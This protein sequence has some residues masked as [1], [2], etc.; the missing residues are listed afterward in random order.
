MDV[1]MPE[2]DGLEATA[3]IRQRENGGSRVP[4]IAMTAHALKGDRQRGLETGMGDYV[5][6][7][8]R[9]EELFPAI[10]TGDHVNLRF[11]AHTLRGA[12]RYFGACR[13]CAH[14]PWNWKTWDARSLSRIRR[15]SWPSWKRKSRR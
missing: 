14:A 10:A 9:A 11:A 4:I 1:Q 8:I 15:R 2:M 3:T 5:A 7:P 12:V 13:A 6:K